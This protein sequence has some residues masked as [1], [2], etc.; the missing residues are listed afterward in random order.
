MRAPLFFASGGA[1]NATQPN[2]PANVSERKPEV[3]NLNV[4]IASDYTSYSRE[5]DWPTEDSFIVASNFS[6]QIS[7][8]VSGECHTEEIARSPSP[9]R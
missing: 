1:G 2:N 8:N 3:I 9:H 6:D 7:D 5:E 4:S